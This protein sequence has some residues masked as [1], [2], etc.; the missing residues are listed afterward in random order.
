MLGAAKS[1]LESARCRLRL[2]TACGDR[3]V[4]GFAEVKSELRQQC[5]EK[6]RLPRPE[7]MTLAA[8]EERARW[9]FSAI[10]VPL[11]EFRFAWQCRAILSN[12][13]GA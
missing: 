4:A 3:E 2:Q 1:D 11:R 10:T 9:L 8:A 7:C 6:G 5:I 12:I 13:A